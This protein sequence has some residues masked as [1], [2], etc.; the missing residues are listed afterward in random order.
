MSGTERPTGHMTLR[1]YSAALTA[2][3]PGT[4]HMAQRDAPIAA[5]H[6]RMLA[7]YYDQCADIS[8]AMTKALGATDNPS[9]G[10]GE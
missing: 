2:M 8:E 10:G 6:L 1:E 5:E 9:T 3:I 4:L 7:R